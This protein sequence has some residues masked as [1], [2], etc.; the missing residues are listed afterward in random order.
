[1]SRSIQIETWSLMW[2]EGGTCSVWPWGVTE[3]T[4]HW[5][6]L[7]SR[8]Q[9]LHVSEP[10]SRDRQHQTADRQTDSGVFSVAEPL[11]GSRKPALDLVLLVQVG[12]EKVGSPGGGCVACDGSELPALRAPAL[13]EARGKCVGWV[14]THAYTLVKTPHWSSF[15][16]KHNHSIY[17]LFIYLFIYCL[18]RATPMAYGASQARGQIGAVAT[19]QCYSHSNLDP[20]HVCD[21]HQGSWLVKCPTTMG[22]PSCNCFR[23]HIWVTAHCTCLPP[24]NLCAEHNVLTVHPCCYKGQVFPLSHG[25]FYSIVCT[26]TY[27]NTYTYISHI[28]SIKEFHFFKYA[29]LLFKKLKKIYI[30]FQGSI[31]DICNFQPRGQFRATGASLHHSHRNARSEPFLWPMPLLAATPDP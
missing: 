19:S 8:E 17:F 15:S 28:Y 21:L 10:W 3:G 24:F 23:F 11:L 18:L 14:C 9:P 12:W 4:V 16:Y 31:C 26:S 1:M 27:I 7:I 25:W 13:Q 20:S 5:A 29:F 30:F 6:S 22:T 2:W